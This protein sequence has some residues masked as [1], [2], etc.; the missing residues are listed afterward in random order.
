MVAQGASE[1]TGILP[2]FSLIPVAVQMV[3]LALVTS[4]RLNSPAPEA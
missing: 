2:P 3:R 1:M 4:H